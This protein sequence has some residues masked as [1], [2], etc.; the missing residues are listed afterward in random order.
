MRSEKI[1]L[2]E[3]HQFSP[4]FLDYLAG[5]E[6]LK[7]LYNRPPVPESFEDQI[8]DK[9]FSAEQRSTLVKVL[10]EQYQGLEELLPVKE[11]IQSLKKENTFTVTTG[12]Q[13]N[14]FTGP[15]Y[16]IYKIVT[17]LKTC[18]EL[19]ERYPAFN[20]IPVY[21]M[22]SEDHD[23]E[24]I[25]H[26]N[27]FGKQYK[28][29]TDQKGPVGEFEVNGLQNILSELPEPIEV[30][31]RAY[32]Q[33]STLTG[34]VRQYVHE[35]F[36]QWGVVSLDASH[37]LLKAS[38][39][40]IIKADL[41]QNKANQLVEQSSERLQGAGY[42]AQIFPREINFFYMKPGLRER[43]VKEGNEYQVMNSSLRFTREE[44]VQELDNHPEHFSPNVVMRPLYQEWILPNLAYVG[45]PAEV[46]YW[47]QLKSL[48]DHFQVLFPVLLPR[49]FA[50]VISKS[51]QNKLEKTG[52]QA[53]QLFQDPHELKQQ[54]LEQYAEHEISLSEENKQLS[55][56][57][58]KIQEKAAAV[59]KSL[60]G[61]VGA[62][63]AKNIKSLENIEKRIK[64]SEEKRHET[65]LK[66]VDSLKEKLFPANSLQER[67]DNFL[68]FY[69][70][71]RAFIPKLV[72]QFDPFDFRFHIMSY[73]E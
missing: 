34:A 28:W 70:N 69:I 37:P 39:K 73:H 7:S 10:S 53:K 11:N 12:H 52:L 35:L 56:L 60:S 55:Q 24:E 2:H 48:F 45:G 25:S 32:T 31:E 47:L 15:L 51:N 18:R 36:G 58:E 5:K 63:A 14:I 71:D 20:F 62:E 64:K 21:W 6:P 43:I 27:L 26:F 50:L 40:D 54:L 72:E 42:K 19:K 33:N 29:E 61:F 67:K 8:K 1:L 17:V 9:S 30:F 49:N 23:F 65:S 68:N 16:F 13:L 57:F 41:L 66:Q 46:A 59:D 22:A 4:L 44:L 3:T 38:F